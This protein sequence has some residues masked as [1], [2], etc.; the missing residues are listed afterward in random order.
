MKIRLYLLRGGIIGFA[1]Y[2]FLIAC[3]FASSRIGRPSFMPV[4][5]WFIAISA[6]PFSW[7]LKMHWSLLFFAALNW[8]IVGTVVGA[9]VGYVK[10]GVKR[11]QKETSQVP[12]P[13]SPAGSPVTL[14][15]KT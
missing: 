15:K 2:L 1:L 6:I 7:F 3:F 8:L 10:C 11:D 9:V 13:T 12:E 5:A 14:G 4:A